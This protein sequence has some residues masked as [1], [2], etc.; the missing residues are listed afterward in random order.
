MLLFLN[1]KVYIQ[2]LNL[3]NCCISGSSTLR[4]FT[5]AYTCCK[6][7][8]LNFSSRILTYLSSAPACR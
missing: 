3:K 8:F 5:P 6:V 1:S 4:P 2:H 7:L